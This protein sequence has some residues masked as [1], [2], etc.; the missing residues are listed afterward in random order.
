MTTQPHHT[1]TCHETYPTNSWMEAFRA[2][3]SQPTHPTNQ[4]TMPERP[5]E[6]ETQAPTHDALS[7]IYNRGY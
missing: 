6:G 5:D 2:A 4:R 1:G 7:A 3:M